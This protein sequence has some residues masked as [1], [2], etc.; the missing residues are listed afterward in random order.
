[1]ISPAISPFLFTITFHL[2][3]LPTNVPWHLYAHNLYKMGDKWKPCRECPQRCH[4]SDLR[5]SKLE[6]T[7]PLLRSFCG[8]HLTRS[9]SPN[10]SSGL[11][12][13]TSPTS[14]LLSLLPA[15]SQ[16]FPWSHQT[17]C[18]LHATAT[19]VP[20]PDFQWVFPHKSQA[21]AQISH[22]VRHFL[23]T[24]HGTVTHI[25]SLPQL[26][27]DC[28]FPFAD[29]FYYIATYYYRL[30]YIDFILLSV[31]SEESIYWKRS[32]ALRKFTAFSPGM[33]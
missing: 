11:G 9:K 18:H 6:H 2:L 20:S 28:L 7:R 19:A 4:Q 12:P 29:L 23:T 30:V 21:S 8:F 3:Q 17:C 1:M 26:Y 15:H 33:P 24:L 14:A 25:L 16:L 32:G 10:L 13:V 31:S 5:I 22:L 27:K